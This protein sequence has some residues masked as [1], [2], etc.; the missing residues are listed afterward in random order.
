MEFDPQDTKKIEEHFSTPISKTKKTILLIPS[1]IGK[2]LHFPLYSP[3]K[4]FTAKA[5]AKNDHYDSVQVAL[6]MVLYPLYLLAITYIIFFLTGGWWWLLTLIVLP[7]TAWS[8]LQLK[9]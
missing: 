1:L 2:V 5:T 7:F 9:K 6:L 8:Y 3:I 4:K